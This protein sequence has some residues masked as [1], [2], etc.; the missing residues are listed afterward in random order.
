MPVKKVTVKQKNPATSATAKPRAKA[1]AVRMTLAETMATLEKAGSAQTK[2]TYMRHGANEPLFGVSFATLKGLLKRIGVDHEL[3]LALWD[4]DNFDA[5]NLAV[6]IADPAKM[7]SA[8]LD[9]W[10]RGDNAMMCGSYVS[11][12][13]CEGPHGLSRAN[14][15]LA[16]KDIGERVA[17]WMLVGMLAMRDEAMP[18]A[19]FQAR[20]AEI[21]K[22]IHAASNAERDTMNRTLISIGCR[23]GALR[24]AVAAAAKRIGPVE[25]D[26]GDTSCK[27][28]DATESTAKAWAHSTAKGFESPAAHERSRDSMRLRC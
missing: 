11:A 6:K 25:V 9:R 5:R 12:L 20:L 28:P 27:T 2:K 19:W 8:D 10:A 14:A 15:W 3:A 24:K 16:S 4:T 21:E 26:H 17:G 22:S 18:D 13:A 1:P 23:S 7:T